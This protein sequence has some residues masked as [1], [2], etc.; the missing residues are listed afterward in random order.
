MRIAL[1]HEYLNQFGGAERVLQ[2]LSEIFPEAPIYTLFYDPEATGYVFEG[3][4]IRTSFLQKAP[5]IKRYHH[6][7]PLF[8]PMAVEQFDFSDFDVVISISASFAKGVITKPN[9]RHICYCLTPTR[10]LWD[11]SQKFMQE[12]KYPG[13]IKKLLP[14]LVTYL[15]LW[16]KEASNR[17]D[18]YWAISNFIKKRIEKYYHRDSSVIY[19]PVNLDK[20]YISEKAEDYFFM[21]GRLVSYKRFDLAIK[22]FNKLGW[23][24]KIAGIGPELNALKKIAG[25]N[26]EFLGSVSDAQLA[27]L[28]SRA[29]AFIF[30]QEE[31]FGIT[32]LESMASGRPVIAFRSGGATET[33]A[34][35]TT[36][37]FF[38]QQTEESML[39]VLK[40]FK[41]ENFKPQACR[42]QANKFNIAVFK[43]NILKHLDEARSTKS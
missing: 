5:F 23:K 12:F 4:D 38:D 27:E 16:D 2:V 25:P 21:A 30:P 40:S 3:K 6:F 31:D 19:C 36:G 43:E 15:R 42:E 22:A 35:G 18:E 1:V 8:M 29:K 7:F 14:P 37:M 39:S 9:T 41:A 13:L 26:I 32:P 24:L 10:F 33:I 34:E 20:F 28:Y 17:P 11:D